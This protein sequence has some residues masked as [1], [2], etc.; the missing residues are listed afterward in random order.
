[1]S[2]RVSALFTFYLF[3]E[4]TVQATHTGGKD[5]LCN[6]LHLLLYWFDQFLC[7]QQKTVT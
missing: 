3:H 7:M 5:I 1:M 4:S 6:F 2:Q